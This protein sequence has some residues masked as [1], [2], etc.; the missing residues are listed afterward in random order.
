MYGYNKFAI[1][2]D[3]SNGKIP[4]NV[5]MSGLDLIRRFILLVFSFLMFDEPLNIY[6]IISM[7]LFIIS[8]ILLFIDYIHPVKKKSIEIETN[9]PVSE[10][11]EEIELLP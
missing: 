2:R 7:T 3:T 5:L 9:I 10:G 11:E 6:I 8:S 1:L 4:S